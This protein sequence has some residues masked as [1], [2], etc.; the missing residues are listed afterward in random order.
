MYYSFLVLANDSRIEKEKVISALSEMEEAVQ[1]LSH[2]SI[3]ISTGS[4]DL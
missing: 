4:T 1:K 3:E 2:L